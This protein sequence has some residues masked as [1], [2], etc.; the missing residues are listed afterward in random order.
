MDYIKKPTTPKWGSVVNTDTGVV[1][2]SVG[3]SI[4]FQ[5]HESERSSLVNKI[6]YLAGMSTENPEL[7]NMASKDEASN[8]V[9]KN[10]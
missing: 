6:L 1:S 2:Y 5:L 3:G 9:I 10:N 4:D 8:D 7:S